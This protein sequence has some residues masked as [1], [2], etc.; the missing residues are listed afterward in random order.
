MPA[1]D[2]E[3][4]EAAAGDLL[5]DLGYPRAVPTPRPEAL[6]HA[7]AVRDRFAQDTHSLG[8]RLP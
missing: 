8:E 7:A 6:A 4:F 3:R 2:V 1:A 5:D